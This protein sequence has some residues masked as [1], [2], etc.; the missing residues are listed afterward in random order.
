MVVAG[1]IGKLSTQ[2]V[3]LLLLPLPWT[4][5]VGWRDGAAAALLPNLR[6]DV[7]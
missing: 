1:V 6:L 2:A 7:P 5:E 4:D 3:F